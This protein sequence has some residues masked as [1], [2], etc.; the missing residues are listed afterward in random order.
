MWA[1]RNIQPLHHTWKLVCLCHHSLRGGVSS[2][3][4]GQGSPRA[5]LSPDVLPKLM[6]GAQLLESSLRGGRKRD[7]LQNSFSCCFSQPQGST[8]EGRVFQA[9][10]ERGKIFMGGCSSSRCHVG[11]TKSQHRAHLLHLPHL[12]PEL[13]GALDTQR[14]SSVCDCLLPGQFR[15][16]S[17]SRRISVVLVKLLE[18]PRGEHWEVGSYSNC[19]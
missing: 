9:L 15:G 11:R 13:P 17:F 16:F 5:L 3:A 14:Q 6:L 10:L 4:R 1:F 7:F 12:P 18:A 19:S 8:L 2:S